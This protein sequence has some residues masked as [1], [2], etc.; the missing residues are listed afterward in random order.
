MVAEGV[1]L[2][3]VEHLEQRARRVAAEVG[4]QLVDFVEQEQRVARADLAQ[5]LQHLARQRADVGAAVAADLGFVTHAAQRH[6]G[7]LAAGRLRD[8]LPQRG[9]ADTRWAHEAQDGCLYLVDALLHREVF[10]DAVLD[11]LEAVVVGVEHGLGIGQVVLDLGLLAPRQADEHVD[12]V[13][14]H[15]G[16]GRH[17]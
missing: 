4:A 11:L 6:A 5:A 17:G 8:R 12:V 15:R 7:V 1:V 10:K 16:F 14:Y 2:L 13:A 3:G 9:L